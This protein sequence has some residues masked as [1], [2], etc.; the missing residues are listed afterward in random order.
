LAA[1]KYVQLCRGKNFERSGSHAE[2]LA[3]NFKKTKVMVCVRMAQP[4]KIERC[5]DRRS[6]SRADKT[7]KLEH[8][9]FAAVKQ[10]VAHA[11]QSAIAAACP[12]RR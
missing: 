3:R 9:A 10:N 2:K 1:V 5:D 11:G 4:N 6:F 8:G 12:A 7:H